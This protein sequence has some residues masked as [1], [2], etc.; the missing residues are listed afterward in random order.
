M[1]GG[2]CGLEE[3]ADVGAVAGDDVGVQVG[4]C[5]GDDGVADYG[6]RRGP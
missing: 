5:L 4:G 1:A 6:L 3:A 2:A